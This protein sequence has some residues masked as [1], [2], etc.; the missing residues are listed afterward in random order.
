MSIKEIKIYELKE[1]SIVCLEDKIKYGEIY[2]PFFLIEKMFDMMDQEEFKKKDKRWLDTGAGSGNFSIYLYKKLNEGLKSIIINDE[3]RHEHIIKKM[4]F[5]V[6]IKKTN[7]EK[8]YKIF[9]KEA[10]IYNVDYLELK[11]EKIDYII[12]NPPYNANG[13]KKVPTNK[14]IKKKEDGETIWKSFVKKSLSILNDEGELLYIIPSIWMKPDKEGIY[15]NILNYKIKRLH[16]MTNTETNKCFKGEAQT[17][18]SMLLLKKEKSDG[19]MS[20]YDKDNEEYI[21]YTL[22]LNSAIPMCNVKIIK[23]L[24]MWVDKYGFLKVYKT[25][26]PS[27]GSKFSD[28]KSKEYKYENVKT[29]KLNGLKP[30]LIKNYSNKEQSY[31]GKRKLILGHG[32]YGFPY[33]DDKGELGISNRDKYIVLNSNLNEL[34]KISRFLSTK[35]ALYIYEATRYRMKYLER[36]AFELIPDITK[37]KDLP[38][39]ITDETLSEYFEFDTK[40]RENIKKLH[41]KDYIFNFE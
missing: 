29:T 18:T 32:M 27:K 40:D 4:I 12:G 34:K 37:I 33:L 25:N 39:E 2:T 28:I 15:E 36:Y 24:K 13:V 20:I 11:L 5:M 7:I 16:C 6:E 22:S 17:P 10:N 21:D 9:G 31:Y 38:K 30:E 1:E 35:T 3:E 26:L 19:K 14:K 41:K 8:L 23:K